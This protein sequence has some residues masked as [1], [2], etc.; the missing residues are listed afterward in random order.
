MTNNQLSYLNLQEAKRNN[1]AT[2]GES[3][4]HNLVTERQNRRNLKEQGRH[5]LVTEQNQQMETAAGLTRSQIAANATKYSAD[6]SAAAS[7][8]AADQSSAAQRYAADRAA[9]TQLRVAQVNKEIQAAHDEMNKIINDANIDNKTKVQL[10]KNSS[11]QFIAQLNRELQEYKI[12]TER[13]TKL[14]ELENELVKAASS[15]NNSAKN[16][17]IGKILAEIGAY[18]RSKVEGSKRKKKK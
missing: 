11:D 16:V 14:R 6:S 5:N 8:Y 7:R 1:A 13:D 3:K 9:Q 2:L 17:V 15:K 12:D 10:L 4:R 18:I